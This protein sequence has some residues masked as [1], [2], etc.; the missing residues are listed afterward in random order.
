[1]AKKWK[2]Y[3]IPGIAIGVVLLYIFFSVVTENFFSLYN[4]ILILRGSCTLLVAAIGLTLVILV[5]QNNMSTGSVVSMAAVMVAILNNKGVPLVIT[6]LAAWGMG[7]LV[8]ALN[9]LLIAKFKFD[10]WVVTFSTMSIMAGLALVI[11]DGETVGFKN[12]ILDYIG[13]GKI[14][15]GLYI[16]IL[17][18]ALI[19]AL[20]VWIEK[21]TMFGYNI[22]SIGGSAVVA[23][24][25]G[26]KEVKNRFMVY[27]VS[28]LLAATAGIMIACMTNS[29][30]PTV[31]SEY[32]FNA[33]AAVV[34]G[35]TPFAGGKGGILGTV[36]G[37]L[38]LK[39]LASGLSMMGIAPTWQ[40]TITGFI[41]VGLIVIDVLNEHRKV[42][43]GLR[44]VYS[45]VE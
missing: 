39:V 11:C 6:L 21:K 24:L 40:K 35:G 17:V 36:L 43:N 33:M 10:Y 14:F 22:F 23:S 15:G 30:S 5:G 8:G 16:I 28:G 13:N 25:S 32:T 3:N 4:T 18:T 12:E 37:T 9:G 44:R 7:A 42:K 1:M 34:I 29:G 41:I 26:V 27:V 2:K 45:D 20:M 31:G 38:L 19:T